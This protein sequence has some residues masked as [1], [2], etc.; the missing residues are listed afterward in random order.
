MG[1]DAARVQTYVYTR[2][3]TTCLT[4]R[5]AV[6]TLNVPQTPVAVDRQ[7]RRRAVEPLSRSRGA[8]PEPN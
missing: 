6:A 7:C 5:A 3:V 8:H 1:H 4:S 2:R